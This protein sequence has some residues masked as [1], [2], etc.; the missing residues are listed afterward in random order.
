MQLGFFEQGQPKP[1]DWDEVPALSYSV[2]KVLANKTPAAAYAY[3]RLLGGE[4]KKPTD[5]TIRGNIL[6]SLILG[7]ESSLVEIYAPD[8]RT[9]AAQVARDGA[10][11]I[12]KIPVIKEHLAEYRELVN[13]HLKP[14]IGNI[15]GKTKLRMAWMSDEDVLCHG[16]LDALN[17]SG[18]AGKDLR[19]EGLDE[20]APVIWDLKSCT[21]AVDASEDRK[22]YDFDY[23]LQCA[24]YLDAIAVL[25][26]DLAEKVQFILVFAEV[27]PPFDVRFVRLA[28]SF[29]EMGQGQWGRAVYEWRKC[30]ASGKWPGS[31]RKIYEVS[32]PIWATRK[33]ASLVQALADQSQAHASIGVANE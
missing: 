26:R 5:S 1:Q 31:G 15:F 10:L 25:R 16:E 18:C 28:R 2:A 6:D 14:K 24:S 22:I 11:A 12:G 29:V 8:F 21:D 3:H 9:K 4:K 27:D 32:A 23:Q 17:E 20:G 30:L 7:N 13:K 19:I 33:E